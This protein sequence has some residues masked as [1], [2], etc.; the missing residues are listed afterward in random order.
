MCLESAADRL[1]AVLSNSSDNTLPTHRIA[2]DKQA[3]THILYSQTKSSW[4]PFPKK[5]PQHSTSSS[6]LGPPQ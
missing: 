2:E 6:S 5:P 4:S 1:C 3:N